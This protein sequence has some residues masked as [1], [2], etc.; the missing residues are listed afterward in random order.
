MTLRST[1]SPRVRACAGAPTLLSRRNKD[2][3]SGRSGTWCCSTRS[4]RSGRWSGSRRRWND[5][6]PLNLTGLLWSDKSSIYRVQPTYLG[7]SRRWVRENSR[8]ITHERIGPVSVSSGMTW[9]AFSPSTADRAGRVCTG[10]KLTFRS[11]ITWTRS[12]GIIWFRWTSGWSGWSAASPPSLNASPRNRRPTVRFSNA[13][14]RSN[15][16]KPDRSWKRASGPDGSKRRPGRGG[17][18]CTCEK[19][20][21]RAS[22][23]SPR[24]NTHNLV[25]LHQ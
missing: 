21:W 11:M 9:T 19:T 17:S 1:S 23:G 20:S 18:S 4:K 3:R 5:D 22:I 2:P 24:A 7:K 8:L 13:K 25:V 16:S 15:Y 12:C 6:V 14:R 10:H